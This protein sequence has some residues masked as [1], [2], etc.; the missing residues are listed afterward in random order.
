MDEFY[1]YEGYFARCITRNLVEV[2]TSLDDKNPIEIRK[3]S[4]M[5]L[6]VFMKNFVEFINKGK[7]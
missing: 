2:K 1:E 7:R 3:P 6:K 4:D 5:P